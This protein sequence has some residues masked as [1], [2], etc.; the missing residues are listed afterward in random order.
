MRKN[1]TYLDDDMSVQIALDIDE[2]F[3][4]LLICKSCRGCTLRKL[5]KYLDADNSV[6]IGLDI[7]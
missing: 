7:E 2:V 6:Q 5:L 3:V 4:F 1:I